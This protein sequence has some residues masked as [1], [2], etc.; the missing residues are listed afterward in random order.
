MRDCRLAREPCR[1]GRRLGVNEPRTGRRCEPGRA[2]HSMLALGGSNARQ[3]DASA[4]PGRRT[5]GKTCAAGELGGRSAG[6]IA[7]PARQK[8]RTAEQIM[9][10]AG[11]KG[12][13]AEQISRWTEQTGARVGLGSRLAV[14]I[15]P[16]A[17]VEA[18]RAAWHVQQTT[19][20]ATLAPRPWSNACMK[21]QGR[22]TWGVNSPHLP[23]RTQPFRRSGMRKCQSSRDW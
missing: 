10:S 4:E 11:L 16:R 21:S 9:P 6:Q 17:E 15:V 12:R 7:W 14:Q 23:S 20:E 5:M 19:E 18:W 13:T 1:A 2:K 8:E 22:C 3:K